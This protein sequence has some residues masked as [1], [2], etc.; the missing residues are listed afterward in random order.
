MTDCLAHEFINYLTIFFAFLSFLDFDLSFFYTSF[1]VWRT[2][3]SDLM[4]FLFEHLPRC[5]N[6]W[7]LRLVGLLK[8]RLQMWHLNGHSPLC[9]YMW[10]LRSPGVGNDFE[11]CEHLCG[12]SWKLEKNNNKKMGKIYTFLTR[13][14]RMHYVRC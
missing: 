10:L 7:F 9:T 8:P 14:K 4:N 2:Y 1:A 11:H 12:F 5:S 13:K 6:M 3:I